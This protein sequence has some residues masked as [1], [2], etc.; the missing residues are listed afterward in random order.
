MDTTVASGSGIRAGRREWIGLA[1][2]ALP[3]LLLSVDIGVLYLA[4]PHL[5]ADLGAD[6]TQ[7]LWILDIYSFMLAGFLVTMGT[8][9]DRIGRRRLLLIGGAAFG[10]AS[11][12]AAYSAR[13]EMLIASRALLGIAGATLMP[14]TMALIRNMFHNPRQMGLAIGVWFSCFVGG[15]TLGP[16][17]GGVLLEHFWWGSAFLLGV[18][19]MVLLLVAGPML[20]PEFR[21]TGA[22]RQDP[23][24][25]VLSLA[26]ILLLIYGLKELARNGGQPLPVASVVVGLVVGVVFVHRQRALTN[27]LLDLRL[28]ASRTFSSALSIML[29]GGVVMA[30]IS[31]LSTMYMQLVHGLSPL[32]AGLWLVPQNV[33]MI[34]GFM[35]APAVAHR[36]RAAYVCA[37]GLALAA[38]GLLLHTQVESVGGLGLLVTGLTLASFGISLPMALTMGLILAA[39]PAEKAGSAASIQETGGEFG[40]AL[41][42]ATL[43]SLGTIVYRNQLAGTVPTGVPDQ[44]VDAAGEGITAAVAAAQQLPGPLSA[45]LLDAARAA[46][47]AGLNVVGGVGAAIFLGLAITAA[48]ALR[49]VRAGDEA[50]QGAPPDAEVETADVVWSLGGGADT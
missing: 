29:L 23:T 13:A 12:I 35:L 26:A 49:H 25:V 48:A 50:G 14:S 7:Q 44:A 31:L 39:A 47:T 38:I 28:F 22:G 18:P 36:V 10:V 1:V 4:L 43:G 40:I 20:L 45:D 30:G 27:P 6:S 32:D 8:L 2:L 33:A 42:I 3:T 41:G 17:V 24:S 5:S 34:I 37:G 9:G 15:M 11:V 21:D 16:L 46:F 19:F